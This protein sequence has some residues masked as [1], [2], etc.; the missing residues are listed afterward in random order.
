MFD[1]KYQI[2]LNDLYGLRTNTYGDSLIGY[3][4]QKPHANV[5]RYVNSREDD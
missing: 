4:N 3:N 2:A 1:A 5:A